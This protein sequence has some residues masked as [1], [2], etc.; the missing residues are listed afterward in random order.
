MNNRISGT[1]EDG[2]GHPRLIELVPKNIDDLNINRM[3]QYPSPQG[4]PLPHYED[5]KMPTRSL[6]TLVPDAD[7]VGIVCLSRNEIGRSREPCH[8][9]IS[10]IGKYQDG[11]ILKCRKYVVTKQLFVGLQF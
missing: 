6:L 4:P 9:R 3:K 8:F 7:H 5:P 11:N 2:E 10:V 1:E